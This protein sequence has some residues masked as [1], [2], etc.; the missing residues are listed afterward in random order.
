MRVESGGHAAFAATMIGVG[1]LGLIKG[2]LTAVWQ[3]VLKGV[4]EVLVYV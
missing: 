4:P 3:P 1:I 2:N